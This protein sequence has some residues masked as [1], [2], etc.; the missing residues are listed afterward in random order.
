MVLIVRVLFQTFKQETF[1]EM[2]EVF[3]W[4][5]AKK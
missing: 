5:A 3:G 1:I 2:D 4:Y